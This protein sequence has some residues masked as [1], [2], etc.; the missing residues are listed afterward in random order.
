ML[1]RS[2]CTLLSNVRHSDFP[3]WT[4]R[5]YFNNLSLLINTCL[6]IVTIINSLV[7]CVVMLSW[8]IKKSS[9]TSAMDG[10]K[11]TESSLLDVS[12]S[13]LDETLR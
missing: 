8:F 1:L 6:E 12:N 3:D 4:G 2:I 9:I 11:V 10:A 7:F 5:D 13:C